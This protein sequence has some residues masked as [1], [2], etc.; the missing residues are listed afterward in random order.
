MP[1]CLAHVRAALLAVTC[2]TLATPLLAQAPAAAAAQTAVPASAALRGTTLDGQ[3]FD[4]AQL[5][6]K[7][8]LLVFWST[9]C[10]VCRDKMPELRANVKGWQGQPFEVIGVSTDRDRRELMTYQQLVN[11][12]IPASQR[13]TTLWR[14]APG[15]QDS[16]G[17]AGVLP[18]AFLIDKQGRVVESYHGRIPP[19]TWD[20][21]AELL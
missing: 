17:N 16:F 21:I 9:E 5:R 18:A 3:A 8:V 20:R 7:V 6:D 15:H 12:S 14:G 13:F 1:R 10:A 19:E 4:L 2:F 11:I